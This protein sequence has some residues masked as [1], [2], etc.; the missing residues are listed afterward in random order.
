MLLKSKMTFIYIARSGRK[1]M[2][3]SNLVPDEE[4][5]K[6]CE[7]NDI[8]D[9]IENMSIIVV[10]DVK[11]EPEKIGDE[12]KKPEVKSAEIISK[13]PLDSAV[14]VVQ[15]LL[16]INVLRA[17]LA[18]DIRPQVLYE[19]KKQIDV[20]TKDDTDAENKDKKEELFL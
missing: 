2:P 13:Y 3:G 7:T 5:E 12:D 19:V 16:D 10:K 8:K 20:V 11:T 18:I 4:G 1:I 6:L 9:M 14:K 15:E 17:L